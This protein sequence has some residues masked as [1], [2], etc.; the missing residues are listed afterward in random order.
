[1]SLHPPKHTMWAAFQGVGSLEVY[2]CV[3]SLPSNSFTEMFV[4]A[5]KS[6]VLQEHTVHVSSLA[7]PVQDNN[8][9]VG[10]FNTRLVMSFFSPFFCFGLETSKMRAM[11][12][13]PGYLNQPIITLLHVWNFHNKHFSVFP[14]T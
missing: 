6:I 13:E 14:G 5:T 4:Y 9:R 3:A 11:H 1:M 8:L 2:T 12:S 7:I 10:E